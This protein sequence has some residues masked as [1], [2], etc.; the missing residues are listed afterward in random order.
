METCESDEAQQLT[1]SATYKKAGTNY[2]AL[3]AKLG[4]REGAVKVIDK[5]QDSFGNEMR[6]FN[7]LGIIQKLMG[8]NDQAKVN[9][10]AALAADPNSFLPNY[11]MGV[12]LCKNSPLESFDYFN[13]ALSCAHAAQEFIYEMNALNSISLL[14]EAAGDY[15]EAI[16]A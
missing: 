1:K 16:E 3:M 7:N 8:N 6:H 15:E 13:R 4:K 10:E 12:L 2:A 5:M 9:Y 11:N 14:H